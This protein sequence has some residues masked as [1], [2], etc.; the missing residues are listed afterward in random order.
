[1]ENITRLMS[2]VAKCS[3]TGC[4][5][6]TGTLCPQGYGRFWY[7]GKDHRAH[8]VAYELLTGSIPSGMT[9]DHLCRNRACCNPSHLEPVSMGENVLRGDTIPARNKAKVECYNG[10]PFTPSNTIVR[11]RY[12]RERRL[13]RRC[14]NDRNNERRMRNRMKA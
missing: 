8:R 9:L 7:S 12:G 3:A 2:K 13:C 5:T 11:V 14:R 6:F 4:W 10:H 1:M